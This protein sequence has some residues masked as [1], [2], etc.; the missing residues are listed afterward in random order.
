LPEKRS[1]SLG[2]AKVAAGLKGKIC[3]PR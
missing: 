2:G 3:E 1:A